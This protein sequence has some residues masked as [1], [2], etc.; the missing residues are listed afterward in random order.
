MGDRFVLQNSR[1]GDVFEWPLMAVLL[2]KSWQM[3]STTLS[4][5]SVRFTRCKLSSQGNRIAVNR[6]S[7]TTYA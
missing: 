3:G 7:S 1:S 2:K 5:K 4:L 6:S